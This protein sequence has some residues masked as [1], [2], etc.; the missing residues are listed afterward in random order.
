LFLLLEALSRTFLWGASRLGLRTGFLGCVGDDEFG[1]LILRDFEQEGVDTSCV[2]RVKGRA[3]GI[4]FYSVDEKGERHYA[5]Y[6]LPGYSD[7]EAMLRPEDIKEEYI[8]QSK[9]LHFSESLLRRS[10]MRDAVF[11]ALRIARNHGVSISYDPNMRAELW[12]DRKGFLETQREAL[13]L[14]DIFLA[15]LKEASLIVSRGTVDVTAEKVLALGPNIVVIRGKS[16][17]QVA[18]P[19]RSFRTP[20]FKVKAVDTSGAGD[21][22]DAG[23]LNGLIR[24]WPLE[25]AVSL[26]SAVAALKVMKAGTRAGLPRIEETVKFLEEQ[27]K[28]SL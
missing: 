17:Y 22:F 8:A 5:F 9:M 25:K 3:T 6:R 26:G 10:E 24:E 19:S 13:S 12:G 14:A 23:F 27:S 11:K 2:K 4:A 18:T 15:T 1:S 21:A 16:F 28:V 7:P 20:V